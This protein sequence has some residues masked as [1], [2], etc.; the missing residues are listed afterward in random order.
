MTLSTYIDIDAPTDQ[1]W[2]ALMDF[3]SYPQ[4]NPFIREIRGEARRGARLF[5]R[6]GPAGK[7]PMTFK[8]AVTSVE[9][10]RKF[11]WLGTLVAGWLFSGEHTFELEPLG[12]G[13]TRFHHRETFSGLLLPLLRNSLDTDTR[14]GFEQM[15]EALKARVEDM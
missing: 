2:A 5:V 6:L 10:N 14:A 15:N 4:W 3:E 9:P 8:P 1:V 13:S 12:S 7:S 11:A